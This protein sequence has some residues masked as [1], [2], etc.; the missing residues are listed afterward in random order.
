[1]NAWVSSSK[2]IGSAQPEL[3]G[4]LGVEVVAY[5]VVA[6]IKAGDPRAH[7]RR[8][9]LGSAGGSRIA[10]LQHARERLNNLKL[11]NGRELFRDCQ[12]ILYS[13]HRYPPVALIIRR[14]GGRRQKACTA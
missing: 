5:P 14:A 9:L 1:M 8:A 4:E 13:R 12:Y 3:I 11:L 6:L 7:R 2:F 10:L